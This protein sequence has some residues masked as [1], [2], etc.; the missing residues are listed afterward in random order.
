LNQSRIQGR[1]EIVWGFG[2]LL[3]AG[4]A[5]FAAQ[6]PSKGSAREKKTRARVTKGLSSNESVTIKVTTNG[7]V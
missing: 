4:T 6:D 1:R 3:A 2:A 7:E 5:G